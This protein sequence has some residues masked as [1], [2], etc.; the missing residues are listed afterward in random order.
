MDLGGVHY[1]ISKS[2][3][4]V[5]PLARYECQSW[6]FQDLLRILAVA[7]LFQRATVNRPNIIRNV[8]IANGQTNGVMRWAGG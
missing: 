3:K 1:H 2:V 6:T 4:I 8:N 7:L 5:S